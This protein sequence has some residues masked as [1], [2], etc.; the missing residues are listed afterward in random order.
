MFSVFFTVAAAHT[1]LTAQLYAVFSLTT[2]SGF[3]THC[4]SF[5]NFFPSQYHPSKQTE[6]LLHEQQNGKQAQGRR[7]VNIWQIGLGAETG[8]MSIKYRQMLPRSCWSSRSTWTERRERRTRTKGKQRKK[9]KQ[10]RQRYHEATREKWKARH[11]KTARIEWR[12]WTIRRERR[13]GNCWHE[14]S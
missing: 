13:H 9:R 5:E 14:G 10:R 11:R 1:F 7:E 6:W 3:Q 4:F 8:T 2:V 12:N